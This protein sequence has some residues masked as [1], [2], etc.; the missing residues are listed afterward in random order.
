MRYYGI[1]LA[2]LQC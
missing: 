1:T 2:C